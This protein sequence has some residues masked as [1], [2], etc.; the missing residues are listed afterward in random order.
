MSGAPEG[1]ATLV[2]GGAELAAPAVVEVA[3]GHAVAYSRRAPHKAEG[4]NEDALAIL[5]LGQRHGLILVADGMGGHA[6]GAR[7][8]TIAI[9]SVV[10]GVG[11]LAGDVGGLRAAALDAV[12]L[13]HEE[14]C[15]LASG[16]GTTLAAVLLEDGRMRP[17]HAGDSGILLVGQRG[18]VGFQSVPHS[19]T[20]YAVEAG[21]LDEDEALLH[22]ERHLVSNYLG[23]E[24]MHV[25][26]GGRVAMRARDTLLVASDGLF[27]N[28]SIEELTELVRVGPLADVAVRLAAEALARME[29]DGG[30]R[31]GKPDDLTFVLFR[32]R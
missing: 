29:G 26:L 30:S 1:A 6:H 17:L 20:G 21:L 3:G 32:P 22:D 13:A 24:E 5:D 12:E 7:A 18:R 19:P 15:G 10:R 14:I 25:Q 2:R 28:L 31:F 11:S 16:A 27:D 9:E 23:C 8:S 4:A